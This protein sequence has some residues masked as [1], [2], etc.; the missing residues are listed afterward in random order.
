MKLVL[1]WNKLDIMHTYE[2]HEPIKNFLVAN[3]NQI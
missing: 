1:K 3:A 2:S